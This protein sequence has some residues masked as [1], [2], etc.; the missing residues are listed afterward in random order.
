MIGLGV[1]Y[2][3]SMSLQRKIKKSK[4]AIA[5]IYLCFY[6][7]YAAYAIFYYTS[8][9]NIIG[10]LLVSLISVALFLS[11]VTTV[12]SYRVNLLNEKP[13]PFR[14]FLKI[15]K[16]TAQLIISLTTVVM[17]LSA[18][19]NTNAFSLIM[20]IISIPTLIL[21][22]LVNVLANLWERKTK[23]GFG[24]KNF[25]PQPLLDE[26]GNEIELAQ[27]DLK[28]EEHSLAIRYL[29]NNNETDRTQSG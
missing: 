21:S 13:S 10:I 4:F 11:A 7:A 5:C 17:V 26:E 22:I 25:I 18:V 27:L 14:H 29:Q 28:Q 19:Q 16:Y 24:K 2:M 15:A 9:K 8:Y 12:L 6:A 1:Y 3:L 20:A 23:N